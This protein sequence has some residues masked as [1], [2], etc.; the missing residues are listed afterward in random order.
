MENPARSGIVHAYCRHPKRVQ[1]VCNRCRLGDLCM[2]RGLSAEEVQQFRQIVHR[3]N[4]IQPGEHLF[5]SG[6][7]LS[8]VVFVRNG[9]LKSYVVDRNGQ[10]QVLGFHLPGGV[11]GF[12]AIHSRLH[13]ANVVA[14]VTS[15]VCHLPF[16]LLSGMA[17]LIPELQSELLRIM[18]QR[19]GELQ[20]VSAD[21]SAN[22]RIAVFLISLSDRIASR[23]HSSHQFTLVMTRRE[24]ASYL[25]MAAETVS[26][27]LARFQSAGLL[28]VDRKR[29]TILELEKLRELSR[30]GA[31]SENVDYFA[32]A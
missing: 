7:T 1:V 24:V 17:R 31:A 5:R 9:C 22:E 29:V 27:V 13:F 25:R 11:V 14:L 28:Q 21:L 12:D 30:N 18:S 10:E 32:A 23:G 3:S 16:E 2:P 20:V 6:D 8:S 26:R 19:I 15:T 4:P